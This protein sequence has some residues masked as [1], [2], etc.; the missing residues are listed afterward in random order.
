M[1]PADR[2]CSLCIDEMMIDS[3][4]DFDKYRK[5]MF[6]NVT[7][8]SDPEPATHLLL[9][10]I[11]GLR[12]NWK[13]VIAVEFTSTK[14]Q[15]SELK[16]FIDNC[17][18][19]VE[20]AG[21]R[22]VSF[23]SDMGNKNQA[24]WSEVGVLCKKD[25]TRRNTF[26]SNDHSI[27]VL[28]DACHLLK[29]LKTA[30]LTQNFYLP[31]DV[32]EKEELPTNVVS[33]QYIKSLW[34]L[35]V[36]TNKSLRSFW[37]LRQ[38]DLTPSNF[39]KMRVGPAVRFFST[40]TSSGIKTGISCKL[41]PESARTTAWFVQFISDWF[42]LVSSRIR[43]KS[44]TLRN[45]PKK[46]SF[47]LYF[48]YVFE[49][50]QIGQ[51]DRW[52]PL[53]TGMVMSTI[54]ILDISNLL[55]KPKLYDYLLLS[56]LNQDSVENVFSQIRLRAGMAPTPTQCLTAVK[57]I[58]LS[59]FISDVKSSNYSDASDV[60]LLDYFS[61]M[62][63]TKTPTI[64]SAPL[65]LLIDN[66]NLISTRLKTVKVTNPD[67][68]RMLLNYDLCMIYNISGCITN[69]L[70]KKNFCADCKEFTLRKNLSGGEH[71][72]AYT[73]HADKGG[74]KYSNLEIFSLALNC[75]LIYDKFSDYIL[76]NNICN[77]ITKICKEIEI[78][79]PKC[80]CTV[81]MKRFIV[82]HFFKIKLYGVC[83]VTKDRKR[84]KVM[85]GTSAPK[86]KKV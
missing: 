30:L 33:S 46:I 3:G 67:D 40:E 6:G 5:E 81:D 85:Y 41:L 77:L 63:T 24:F 64:E 11:R 21:L 47:L 25:G 73:R 55:L 58:T 72:K 7:L 76:H 79:V 18:K 16:A 52:K 86:R 17:I 83:S 26:Q 50:M 62:K 32:V 13:Q 22:V 31:Q 2:L 39:E 34:N 66:Q 1:S 74:L 35:E 78:V 44:I 69:A 23:V 10:L 28:P 54:S 57:T 59:Q 14:L 20:N 65:P 36:N 15:A 70:L 45:K 80:H 82:E 37:H 61:K 56:R 9:A 38:E 42:T 71:F 51:E 53:N 19:H 48:A 27:F 43:K 68:V 84:K 75:S 60:H 49:Q 12:S 4:P 29:N 8:G